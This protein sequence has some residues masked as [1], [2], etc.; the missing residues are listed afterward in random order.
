ML[1]KYLE[2]CESQTRLDEVTVTVVFFWLQIVLE[3]MKSNFGSDILTHTLMKML[4]ETSGS[5]TK[6]NNNTKQ[7]KPNYG[8]LVD[9][10]LNNVRFESQ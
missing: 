4:V 5:K 7:D 9:E 1:W 10:I 3:Q 2:V 8:I 6:N